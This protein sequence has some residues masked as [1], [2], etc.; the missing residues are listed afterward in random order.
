WKNSTF[1]PTMENDDAETSS[2]DTSDDD[3][4]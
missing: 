2:S 4:V 1:K 3:D